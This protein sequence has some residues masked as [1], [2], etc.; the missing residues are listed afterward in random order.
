MMPQVTWPSAILTV[1]VG[2]H[3]AC[4]FFD[5]VGMMHGIVD[6]YALFLL[7]VQAVVMVKVGDWQLVGVSHFSLCIQTV[8]NEK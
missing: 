1:H 6:R 2:T 3:A 5:A 8:C 4:A 7:T